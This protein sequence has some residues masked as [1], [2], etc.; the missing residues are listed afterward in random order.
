MEMYFLV[1]NPADYLHANASSPVVEEIKFS[2]PN[3]CDYLQPDFL[4]EFSPAGLAD[5]HAPVEFL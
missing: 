1:T 3:E 5:D 2:K 4:R